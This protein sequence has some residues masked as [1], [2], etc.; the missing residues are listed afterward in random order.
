MLFLDKINL[1]GVTTGRRINEFSNNLEENLKEMP[2]IIS[3]FA[4]MD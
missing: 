2:T 4:A 3:G 1:Q